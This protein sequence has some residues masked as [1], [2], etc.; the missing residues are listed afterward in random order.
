MSYASIKHGA[1]NNL[2]DPL[3]GIIKY[4]LDGHAGALEKFM[5]TSLHVLNERHSVQ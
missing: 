5:C 2:L 4:A 1:S 3:A